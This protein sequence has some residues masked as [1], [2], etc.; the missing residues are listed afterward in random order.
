LNTHK[1]NLKNTRK[2]VIENDNILQINRLHL[3]AA[4][5][6]GSNDFLAGSGEPPAR[7]N[8]PPARASGFST[9]S[10][11]FQTTPDGGLDWV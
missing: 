8:E 11:R 6:T 9:G 5:K 1:K 10:N 2:E 7:S 3:W 4:P